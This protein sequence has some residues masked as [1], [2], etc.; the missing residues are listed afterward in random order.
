MSL[1]PKQRTAALLLGRGMTAM[2]TAEKIGICHTT[3]YKWKCRHPEFKALIE[4]EKKYIQ[5]GSE[6]AW[7]VHAS[8]IK[9]QISG[10]IKV[11][12]ETL[13]RQMREGKNEMAVIKAATY[14][15]DK[16]GSDHI[17]DIRG[18]SENTDEV[19]LLS[20]LRLVDGG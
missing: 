16:Y 18:S 4:A 12:L 19:E 2:E 3:I 5:S 8:A 14:I 15:L 11:S 9:A 17:S 20:A 1:K 7:H 6:Y 13:H 10:L